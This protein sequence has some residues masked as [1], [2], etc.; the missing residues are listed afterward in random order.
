MRATRQTF[1]ELALD[2]HCELHEALL[3]RPNV[4]GNRHAAQML[5]NEKARAGAS[6]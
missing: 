1:R 6:G 2:R 3:P 5:E 4:G